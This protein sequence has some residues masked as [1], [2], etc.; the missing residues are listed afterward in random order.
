MKNT[1]LDSINNTA[2]EQI[3]GALV[4]LYIVDSEAKEDNAALYT[5]E[6]HN[7]RSSTTQEQHIQ[8]GAPIM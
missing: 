4:F 2:I 3:I 5:P 8:I 1:N 6:F 7:S